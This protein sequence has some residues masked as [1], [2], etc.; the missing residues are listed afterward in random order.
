[1]TTPAREAEERRRCL[2]AFGLPESV[3]YG[4]V[5]M[6]VIPEG[7][8]RYELALILP[9]G[10]EERVQEL[11]G[12][13]RADW[14]AAYAITFYVLFGPAPAQAGALPGSPAG[15]EVVL[16]R[17]SLGTAEDAATGAGEVPAYLFWGTARYG[18]SAVYALTRAH[19]DGEWSDGLGGLHFPHTEP[20][21]DLAYRGLEL[22]RAKRPSRVR[23]TPTAEEFLGHVDQGLANLRR[24]NREPTPD[25]LIGQLPWQKSRVYELLELFRAQGHPWATMRALLRRGHR[26]SLAEDDD[27]R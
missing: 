3:P 8:V 4:R 20:E 19:P 18:T 17:W 15:T 7:P 14:D 9:D 27:P 26:G 13:A 1:M 21:R 5:T 16:H 24:R 22:L 10:R 12:S 2:V 25:S 6:T 11:L 23:L